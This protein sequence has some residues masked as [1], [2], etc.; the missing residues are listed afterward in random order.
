MANK[1]LLVYFVAATLSSFVTGCAPGTTTASWSEEVRL[2]DGSTLEVRRRATYSVENSWAGDAPSAIEK[3]STL[4]FPGS[5][6]P[7]R[8]WR[9]SLTPLLL[10]IDKATG[11]CVIV[12]TTTSG[13]RYDLHGTPPSIYWEFRSRGGKW[14]EVPLS[15]S[16]IGRKT[17]LYFSF[18]RDDMPKRV[19]ADVTGRARDAAW[20]P[21]LYKTIAPPLPGEALSR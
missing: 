21:K 8:E 9:Q 4:K 6:V 16:S 2:D 17:N 19:T 10:Y 7:C 14:Q 20:I 5:Q 18:H 11:D 12:A 3:T 13:A 1:R 15:E